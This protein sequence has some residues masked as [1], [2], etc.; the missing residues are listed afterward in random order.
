MR[1]AACGIIARSSVHRPRRKCAC[2]QLGR[3]ISYPLRANPTFSRDLST[4]QWVDDDSVTCA[5]YL[6]PDVIDERILSTSGPDPIDDK[7]SSVLHPTKTD[8]NLSTSDRRSEYLFPRF[9]DD[10]LVI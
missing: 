2:R 4:A 9:V 8:S 1:V 10:V 5:M 6:Q 7:L 3:K